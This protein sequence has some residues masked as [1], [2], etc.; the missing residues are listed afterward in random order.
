MG[1]IIKSCLNGLALAAK[2]WLIFGIFLPIIFFVFHP[3]DPMIVLG[4]SVLGVVT[5]YYTKWKKEEPA[6]RQATVEAEQAGAK[7]EA[8]H[9]T[10]EDKESPLKRYQN[11]FYP[12][13][14]SA[15]LAACMMSC[16]YQ[17]IYKNTQPK[18]GM[19]DIAIASPSADAAATGRTV[20]ATDSDSCTVWSASN[21]EMVHLADASQYVT[22]SDSILSDTTV[23]AMNATLQALDSL[24]GVKSAIVVCRRVAGGDTYRTAVDLVNKHHIG[25]RDTGR[26][27]CVVVAYDQRHYTIAPSGAMESVLTDIECSQLGRDC[28][29]PYLQ[30]ELPDSA[31]LCLTQALHALITTKQAKSPDDFSLATFKGKGLYNETGMSML[32]IVLLCLLFGYLDGKNKWTKPAK[33]LQAAS[34]GNT[35]PD[36]Q[37]AK[38]DTAKGTDSQHPTPPHKGGSYGGGQSGGGGATGSW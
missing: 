29:Q 20:A 30:R 33:I 25:H 11:K 13:F 24:A 26:G 10:D 2:P 22:N 4:V 8:I 6:A 18:N 31:L 1:E 34:G 12:A 35:Q 37:D 14:W 32:L 19:A 17:F 15:L 36:R 5:Y 23:T 21:I 28:L 7:F 27:L 9:P 16:S 38:K 3:V